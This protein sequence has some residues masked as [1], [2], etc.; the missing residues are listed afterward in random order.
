[1]KPTAFAAKFVAGLTV[2]AFAGMAFAAPR[3]TPSKNMVGDAGEIGGAAYFFGT[4][5]ENSSG[6]VVGPIEPQNG[7]TASGVNLPFASISTANP[8]SGTQHLRL[9][10][11]TAAGQGVNQLVLSPT[12]PS[13]A[14]TA[15]TVYMKLNISNDGGADYHVIGQA[16]SQ[17]FLSWRIVF[18]WSG[19]AAGDPGHIYILDDIGAGLEF[20]NTGVLWTENA[21]KELR[22]DFNPVGAQIDYYYDGVLIYSGGLV[23]GTAVEQVGALHDNFQLGGETCDIDAISV[24]TF[25]E[26]PVSVQTKTWSQVKSLMR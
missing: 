21:Y 20:V 1:M 18:S 22:V 14:N 12:N 15:S 13:P 5:F 2:L 8:Y 25:G 24:Q 23:A 7:W 19:D 4:G 9:I 11:N 3:E 26:P 17:A 6:F 16:P 10:R